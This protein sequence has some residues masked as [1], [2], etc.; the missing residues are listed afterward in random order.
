MPVVHSR[1]ASPTGAPER[2]F[3]PQRVLVRFSVRRCH[4]PG[5]GGAAGPQGACLP[6]RG[7]PPAAQCCRAPGSVP[8]GPR[9]RAPP[10]GLR[11]GPAVVRLLPSLGEGGGCPAEKGTP[12]HPWFLTSCVV[13]CGQ[14]EIMDIDAEREKITKEIKELERI[15]DPSSSSIHVEVSES[16]LDS[17][18]GTG[19]CPHVVVTAVSASGSCRPRYAG[20]QLRPSLS[21]NPASA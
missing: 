21:A 17:D 14:A 11:P 2:R 18:S 8:A 9:S 3:W 1:S 15:L 13:F 5:A 19:K 16:S 6:R 20:A 7:R 12:A 10:P 4:V